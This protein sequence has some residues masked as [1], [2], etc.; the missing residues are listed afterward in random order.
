MKTGRWT[1]VLAGITL[2]AI[3]ASAAWAAQ[4]GAKS[5]EETLQEQSDLMV[6]ECK[7]SDEQQKTLKEKFKAKQDAL[8]AWDKANSEKVKTAEEAAKAA[9]KGADQDAK[10]KANSDLKAMMAERDQA[11]AEADKAVLAVLSDEQKTTWAGAQLAQSTLLRYKKA[12]LTDDQVAKIKSA[13]VIAAKDLAGFDGDDKKDK[14]GRMTTEK[15][16]KWAIDNVILTPEQ[17]GDVTPK[18]PAAPAPAAAA[19]AAP[20]PAAVEPKAA[21]PDAKKEEPPAE[22]KKDEA[23]KEERPAEPK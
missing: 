20:A 22:P 12:N 10:K 21:V 16:L 23:K 8:E 15:S 5:V 1:I 17:R 19:P 3:S 6:R 11:A 4:K 13:C 7:L 18:K 9:R 2:A 14:Q